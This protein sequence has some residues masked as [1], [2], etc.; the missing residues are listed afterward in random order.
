MPVIHSLQYP[1][2]GSILK[3]TDAAA[4][5]KFRERIEKEIVHFLT[6]KMAISDRLA[7]LSKEK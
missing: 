3:E 1:N 4:L 7:E 5:E 6:L 2:V